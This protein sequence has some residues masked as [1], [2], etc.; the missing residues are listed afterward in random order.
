MAVFLMA[1]CSS[2][3]GT[4][5]GAGGAGTTSTAGGLLLSG[6]LVLTGSFSVDTILNVCT[7]AEDG[8]PLT[9]EP[10]FSTTTGSFTINV[11]EI[12]DLLG[13]L[14]PSGITLES[15]TVTFAAQGDVG[16]PVLTPRTFFPNRFFTERRIYCH[17]HCDY[18]RSGIH[19]A[20]VCSR[21]SF[22]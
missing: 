15:Y 1:G 17:S 18:S 19:I 5:G 9:F 6:S 10:G 16:A 4:S 11:T 13:G 21:Q 22:G 7:T 3:A 2:G 20:G 8:T 12:A 14:F